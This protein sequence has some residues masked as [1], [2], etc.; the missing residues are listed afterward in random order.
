[1]GLD[2][3][4][5]KQVAGRATVR[6]MLA[7]IGKAK[8]HTRFNPCGNG[9]RQCPFSIDAFSTSAGTARIGNNLPAPFTMTAG[10]AHTEKP[11]L[12]PQL[13]APAATRTSLESRRGTCATAVTVRTGLP[14]RNLK[15]GLLP[16][17]SLFKGQFEVV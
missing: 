7:L 16:T 4:S 11:L 1:M 12:E 2:A 13:P 3:D 10:P 6:T 17:H 9:D 5:H 15:T 8:P 14:S